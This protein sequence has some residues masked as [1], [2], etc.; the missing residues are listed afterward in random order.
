MFYFFRNIPTFITD[1]S[2]NRPNEIIIYLTCSLIVYGVIGVRLNM[3][4]CHNEPSAVTLQFTYQRN[5]T[6]SF[7]P[8]SAKFRNFHI[9]IF[10]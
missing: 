4:K 10:V 3:I 2:I 5:V 6:L 9:F 8:S 1:L 7:F